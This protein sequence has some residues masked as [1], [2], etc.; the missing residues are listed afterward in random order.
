MNRLRFLLLAAV[1]LIVPASTVRSAP[2][3]AAR[4]GLEQVPET[5]PIVLHIRGIQGV[6]DRLVELMKQAA[7]DV[8]NKFQMQI[9]DFFEKG[10]EN[11][12]MG[13]KLRGLAKDGPLFLVVTSLPKLN[14]PIPEQPPIAL[15]F[16]VNNY[17]EFRN[18]LL[19]EE[20]RKNIKD[21]GN[22]IESANVDNKPLYFVDRKGYAVIAQD[23]E[24]ADSFTKK[25]AGLHAKLS[26]EQ[27][28]KLTA[29]DVGLYI[30]ME[31][32]NK[33]YGDLIKQAKQAI[34]QLLAFAASADES[35]RKG[36]AFIFQ[37]IEDIQTLILTAELR[38]G[39]A[40]LHLQS[41]IKE[42]STTASYLQDWQP[43]DLNKQLER[44]PSDQ[45]YYVGLKGSAALYKKL[46]ALFS[47]LPPAQFQGLA[48]LMKELVKDGPD[49]ILS[50]G[51]FPSTG[52]D[53][54]YFDEPTKAVV[55]IL[56]MY[57]NMDLEANSLK[58]KPEIKT[59]AVKHGDFKLHE[60][61]LTLDLDKMAEEA[62]S[63]RGVDGKKATLEII[64]ELHSEQKRVWFGTD[65]KTVVEITAPDWKTARKM[66]D[67]YTKGTNATKAFREVCK[68]MPARTSL[69]GIGDAVRLWKTI[70]PLS[71]AGQ[72][73]I[74]PSPGVFAYVGL[75]LTLQPNYGGLD[76]FV[77]L[78]AAQ[79]FYKV[80]IQPEMGE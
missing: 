24:V 5:A 20:E 38:P 44:L 37:T 78:T 65:G 50:S 42:N 52:L 58:K 49:V 67:Q 12:L 22:G 53:A 23:K 17:K 68:G 34:E 13:R 18:N 66:L 60:V 6:H 29:S 14:G 80:V 4:S 33:E 8:L 9:D 56:E 41:D 47:N 46:A 36:I 26:K 40:A 21:E 57:R 77:P 64:K 76:L 59:N 74:K 55:A 35:Q 7:P 3:P 48:K 10:P 27:I 16:A 19:T 72:A 54:F 32:V 79:E 75:A 70:K 30:N 43:V 2:V 73:E 25:I 15:V 11:M 61:Q 1:C 39:G 62:A 69:L 31:T 28:A 51:S 63:G 71:A 45:V